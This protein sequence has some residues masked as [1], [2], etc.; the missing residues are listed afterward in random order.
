MVY[1]FGDF[2]LE[3]EGRLLLRHSEV[4]P[5]APKAVEVLIVLV[6]ANGKLVGKQE[7]LETVWPETFVEEANLTHHVSALRKALGEDKTGQRFI[8][9]IPRRGYRFVAPIVENF[10]GQPE[11]SPRNGAVEIPVDGRIEEFEIDTGVNSVDAPPKASSAPRMSPRNWLAFWLAAGLAVVVFGGTAIFYFA[12]FASA[13]RRKTDAAAHMEKTIS[14]TR[15]N[16][17]ANV[18]ATTISPDGK[19]VAYVQ[20]FTA[21]VGGALY[22]RQLETNREIC[23]LE[24]DE[25]TFG[26]I[27]FSPDGA[28]IYFV[29]F[30]RGANIG[31]LFSLPILGG[32]P[33]RI[34][35][36]DATNA[37]FA[38]SPDH[39]QIAFYRDDETR[40]AAAL[41]IAALDTG[42][43]KVI[44]TGT[45][46]SLGGFLAWSPDGGSL[47]VV[48]IPSSETAADARIFRFDLQTNQA[49]PLHEQGFS[50]IGKLCFTH[51]GGEI[52]FVGEEKNSA[53]KIYALDIAN[54]Q[55]RRVTNDAHAYGFY[56][57]GLT[58]D[59][60]TLVADLTESKADVWSV[61][62]NG[63]LTDAR[64]VK[65]GETN[66]KLGLATL[67]DGSIAYTARVGGKPDIW[68]VKP[69]GSNAQAI[70]ADEFPE[71]GLTASPDGRLIVFASDRRLSGAGK[72]LYRA[73]A[74]GGGD[75]KQLTFGDTEDVQPD[76]SPD[77]KWIVYVSQDATGGTLKKVS[78]EG[79]TPVRL[80]DY[81]VVMPAF[82]PDGTR[83]AAKRPSPSRS[84]PGEL[85][86]IPATGGKPEKT[87]PVT[88]FEWLHV[89]SPVRWTPDGRNLVFSLERNSACNL[90]RQSLDGSPPR[91]MTSFTSDAIH[92]FAFSVDGKR[93]L[94]SRGLYQ[95]NAVLIQNFGGGSGG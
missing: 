89:V 33:K 3:T 6:R 37:F 2:R 55:V 82:S 16:D 12:N 14:Y 72:H 92:G 41:I 46:P 62:E 81:F 38:I 4:V 15:V 29:S 75:V 27:D 86:V 20:N 68:R 35:E 7:I 51:D 32:K 53:Q 52:F 39:K 83:I 80:T 91:Q 44:H 56:G 65:A 19:F 57:L 90:W 84:L 43:E 28:L 78:I 58:S 18:A 59:G 11:R 64:R 25:R 66:G 74:D 67:P 87:F 79:G 73:N 48:R 85:V 24:P 34:L 76:F 10:G 13:T 60:K 5:L 30:E 9:T 1:E 70:T 63:S 26:N 31:A 42:A 94:L 88:D 22:V 61:A 45:E 95:T 17:G 21:G 77:G 69:D 36:L 50:D 47:G 71:S 40:Q 93:I 49:T 54:G 23:V 8:E